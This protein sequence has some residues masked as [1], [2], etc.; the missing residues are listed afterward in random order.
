VRAPKRRFTGVWFPKEIWLAEDLSWLAKGLLVEIDSLSSDPRGCFASNRYLAQ[1]FGV[2]QSQIS[3]TVSD[4]AERGL[5]EVEMVP[6]PAILGGFRRFMRRTEVALRQRSLPAREEDETADEEPEDEPATPLRKMRI[7]P[8]HSAEGPSAKCGEGLRMNADHRSESRESVISMHA[9][10]A[11]EPAENPSTRG[12][13]VLPDAACMHA[14]PTT[15]PD[16]TPAPDNWRADG[17]QRLRDVF[18]F[19][20]GIA[21]KLAAKC[22]NPTYLDAWIRRAEYLAAEEGVPVRTKSGLV[23]AG[24]NAGEEAPWV[25]EPAESG[26][27]GGTVRPATAVEQRQREI[28]RRHEEAAAE[29]RRQA[30]E[31]RRQPDAEAQAEIDAELAAVKAR[32]AAQ[33]GMSPRRSA[34]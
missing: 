17:T 21:G 26:A 5:I 9:C 30:A 24:I 4:L 10:M 23:L 3:R 33:W 13:G 7:P 16:P 8:T 2:S 11:P 22:P 18:G 12:G 31:L 29:T 34:P 19:A 1:F 28:D 14:P 15:A 27:K 32:M 25:P 6:A 20:A